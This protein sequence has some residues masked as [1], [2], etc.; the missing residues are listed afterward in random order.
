MTGCNEATAWMLPWFIENF[1]KHNTDIPIIFFDF[2]VDA[3]TSAWMETTKQF[4]AIIRLKR[5]P[6]V[7]GWFLKPRALL[8]SPTEYTV[9]IDT[10]CEVL[11]DLSGI[12]NYIEN[13]KLAMAVDKPWTKRHGEQWHN[14]GVIGVRRKPEILRKW[15]HECEHA[16]KRGDQETLHAMLPTPLDKMVSITDIP[17]EYNWLRVQ[18]QNDNEDSPNKKIM[19]WTGSKGKDVIKE[20][21]KGNY[22]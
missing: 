4:D 11:G 12:F 9:W 16:P 2:G 14:S 22:E 8:E 7:G 15:V 21:I 10:D 6:K 19:H 1:R 3:A 20:K 18:L 13:G 5:P 17:N